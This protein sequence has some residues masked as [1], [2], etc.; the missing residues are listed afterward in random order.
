MAFDLSKLTKREKHIT[1]ILIFVLS[2]LP[3]FYLTYPSWNAYVETGS[4]LIQDK[5]RLNDLEGQI[6]KL[7]KYKSQNSELAKKLENQKS[8][9]AKSYEIDFLVQDLKKICDESSITIESFTPTSPEPINIIL[10]KQA[11]SEIL[12]KGNTSKKEKIKKTLDK[13]KGQDLPVDLY[14]FPI[15]VKVTGNFTDILELFKKLEKYGRV[16][17]VENISI[18]KIQVKENFGN[19]LTKSKPKKQTD[20]GGLFGSFDLVAYNLP[21]EEEV[22]PAIELEKRFGSTGN[23]GAFRFKKKKAE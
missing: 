23:K 21:R 7:Q 20:T 19:R 15:E 8:Y 9:L 13:L 14:R 6:K 16:I 1:G 2:T 18:G 12:G 10:E 11:E 4:K 22:L 17:S 5:R 3:F